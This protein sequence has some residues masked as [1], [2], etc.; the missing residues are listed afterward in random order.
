MKFEALLGRTVR[1]F[2]ATSY[3]FDL[4]LFDQYLLR[5][6]AQ[7]P[8][9]AVVLVDH[10]KL[11]AVWEHLQEGQQYLARQVGRRYLLRGVRLEGGGAFHP[12][13]YLFARAGDTTLAV[14]SGNLTRSGIDHGR[15]SFTTFTTQ[16]D[17]DLPSMRAWAGWIGR[18][19][20]QQDD[21][22]L[23]D[24]WI[25]LRE[26]CPWFLG[27][28]EGSRF[29]TNERRPLL[30]QLVDWL[31]DTV[32]DLHV[33]AP[34]FDRDAIALGGLVKTCDPHRLTLYVGAGASV[35]GPSLAEVLSNAREVRVRRFEPRT[36][37]HAKLIG[38]VGADGTGV[39]MSG[40]P[41]L[42]R[43][44]LTMTYG[45]VGRGN[46]E[47]AVVRRGEGDQVLQVFTGSGLQLID[48]SPDWLSGL[49]FND[50][51]PALARPIVLRSALWLKDGR[52][53]LHLGAGQLS[54]GLQVDWEG[55]SAPA[56]VGTDCITLGALNERSPLPM[57]VS[58]IGP[59][60]ER[61]SNRVIV[62]DPAALTEALTGSERKSSGRPAEMNGVEMSPLVRL[63]LWAH[64][65]FI[66]DP[67]ETTAFRRAQDAAGEATD[68][69]DV[70]DF[71]Q[72]YV[73]EELQYDPRSQTYRPLTAGT[74]AG[75]VDELLREL[76]MLLH[77][78]PDV[79]GSAVLRILT[80]DGDGNGGGDSGAP[81]TP[82]TMD[83]RQRV[84]A[85]NL[86][87]RWANAVADPRHALLSPNAPVVNY[88]TLLVVL[89]LAWIN[90]ALEPKRLRKLLLS[91]LNSFV[92]PTDGQGF[93]GRLGEAERASAVARI[94]PE[95]VEVAAGLAYVVLDMPDWRRDIYDWQPALRRGIELGVILA[96]PLSEDVVAR[97]TD[98]P[99]TQGTVDDLLLQRVDW[100]DETTWCARLSEELELSRLTIEPFNAP[101]V[102]FV[103]ITEGCADPLRD[104]RLLSVARG[105]IDFKRAPAIAVRA[106]ADTF[107]F[108]PG[109]RARALV[110]GERFRTTDPVNSEL[111]REIEDQGGCWA[112]L[113]GLGEAAAA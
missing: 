79:P 47:T 96:G 88:E 30:N 106:G 9:N 41:N 33:T 66:F 14:G 58:L 103:A 29:L 7:S 32:V 71:W 43:A 78:A 36:Y 44:A 8:L 40:S 24:R 64:D 2:W 25:A 70:T 87:A 21:P 15:E 85:F 82:W 13:T 31:P 46:C 69:E 108:E 6:L 95:L 1:G 81:G 113:L 10:D 102:R 72:R 57:L 20:D 60:G 67:E 55:A 91:L 63:V 27:T 107:V 17:D 28:T 59:T 89:V 38:A 35:H 110:A 22:L 61:A 49:E 26:T 98:A 3:S 77:A 45:D 56:P 86:L 80:S 42:S 52:I 97:I 68:A 93:L 51:H 37:V 100:V 109:A 11:A 34:F 101:G 5:R 12:K 50:D 19:V 4:K 48:V 65:K 74:A 62:D 53:Q 104:T 105:A 94:E 83:A 73:E 90:D 16:R 84:R 23:R 76:Q 92:G 112:D 18:I 54:Y 99:V 39:V 111:L 75:P